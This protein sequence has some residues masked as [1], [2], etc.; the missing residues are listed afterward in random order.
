LDNTEAHAWKPACKFH[1]LWNFAVDKR[2]TVDSQ[3]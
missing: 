3:W 1:E 2:Q